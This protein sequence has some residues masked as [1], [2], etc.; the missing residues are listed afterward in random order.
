MTYEE[1]KNYLGKNDLVSLLQG[2]GYEFNRQGKFDI[3]GERT[4]SVSIN[5]KDLKIKD[6]GGDFSGDVFNLLKELHGMTPPED[7]RYVMNFLGLSDESG[8]IPTRRKIPTYTPPPK[9]N[10]KLMADLKVRARRHLNEPI[11][12]NGR[13]RARYQ[14]FEF[15]DE[16]IKRV[17][18]LDE[19]FTKLF[20][21]SYLEVDKDKIN[22]IFQNFVGYDSYYDCPVI[23]LYDLHGNVVNIIKYR[24][25][26][27]GEVVR[28]Y[29]YSKSEDV[30][31]S[32]YLYPFQYETERMILK[33]GFAY[34]GEGLKNALCA[35]VFGLPYISIES[36][37]GVND[38]LLTYL[39]SPKMKDVF[40]IGA[41]D[42][43]E[44][45]QRAYKEMNESIPMD[46]EFLFD[47]GIDFA[48]KMRKDN[49]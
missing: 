39:K 12:R 15:E 7:L 27:N 22:Y 20:E 11:I 35:L 41:F 43:D 9:D 26:K 47:S 2:L 13:K 23:I 14:W 21:H 24:P 18:T 48:D 25:K 4:P 19:P 28:K 17:A 6:F 38:R 34:V 37:S 10:Q 5:P 49:E 8:A 46:N 29:H 45:G 32:S 30:P 16:E 40:Y 1:A 33:H 3:R 36:V 31:D 44:A 42:G